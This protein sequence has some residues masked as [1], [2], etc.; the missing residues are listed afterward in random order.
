[1]R[2]IDADLIINLMKKERA[3]DDCRGFWHSTVNAVI[4]LLE[5]APTV[6]CK[7]C[8]FWDSKYGLTKT[9]GMCSKKKT[10]TECDE[11]CGKEK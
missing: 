4:K 10:Y 2:P 1:M 8:D 3:R 11:T 5:S 6:K 9:D 7:E